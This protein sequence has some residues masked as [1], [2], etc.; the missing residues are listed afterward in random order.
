M[1]PGQKCSISNL[2]EHFLVSEHWR[3]FLLDFILGFNF[4]DGINLWPELQPELQPDKNAKN[5]VPKSTIIHKNLMIPGGLKHSAM[6]HG[7]NQCNS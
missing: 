7:E 1:F 2:W 5:S 6:C 4:R 3:L